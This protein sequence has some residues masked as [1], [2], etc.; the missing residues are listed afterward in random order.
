[1]NMRCCPKCRALPG[2]CPA[3]WKCACHT[4]DRRDRHDNLTD[5][6]IAANQAVR[7]QLNR[8]AKAKADLEKYTREQSK[9]ATDFAHWR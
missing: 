7:N 8:E 2:T 6:E 9:R 1:M 4:P 5:W 3:G